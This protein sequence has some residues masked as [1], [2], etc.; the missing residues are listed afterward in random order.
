MDRLTASTWTANS[1]TLHWHL[2]KPGFGYPS[3]VEIFDDVQISTTYSDFSFYPC[4]LI[5]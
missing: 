5:I 2:V 1:A 4:K 3:S